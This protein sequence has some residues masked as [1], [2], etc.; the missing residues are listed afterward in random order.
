MRHIGHAGQEGRIDHGRPHPEE[1]A[2]HEPGP[3]GAA[4]RH[5]KKGASLQEHPPGN[6]RLPAPPVREGSGPEL[7]E[8]PHGGVDEG[9]DSDLGDRESACGEIEGE[10]APGQPVLEVGDETRLARIHQRR[11]PPAG[12]EE[13][14]PGRQAPSEGG[15]LVACPVLPGFQRHVGPGIANEEDTEGEPQYREGDAQVEGF[16]TEPEG[17]GHI[18]GSEGRQCHRQ[19]A[20]ELVQPHGGA[21]GPWTHQ[22]DL[23]DDRG[24]PGESLVYPQEHVGEEHPGPGRGPDQEKGHRKPEEPPHQ[25]DPLPT[26]AVGESPGEEVRCRLHQTEG[27]NEGE[28]GAPGGKAELLLGQKREDGALQP[29]HGPDK[30]VDQDQEPE[31]PPVLLKSQSD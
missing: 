25:E 3:E 1:G 21:P 26:E 16:G 27:G 30:G 10:E 6:E 4:S 18:A 23:H 12:Q 24:G 13:D 5:G 14:L 20:P 22:I 28:D 8:P 9:Q 11:M 2:G 19:V 29:H 15:I 31:L 17:L 7:Q